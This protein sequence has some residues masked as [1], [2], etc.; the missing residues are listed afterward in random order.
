MSDAYLYQIV[1]ENR[2][3]K[4]SGTEFQSLFGHVMRATYSGFREVS[5]PP[6]RGDGGNDGWIREKGAYYQVYAPDLQTVNPDVQAQKK[7]VT[8]FE[9]LLTNWHE[10]IP[11]RRFYFVFNRRFTAVSA[12]LQKIVAQLKNKYNLEDADII[13]SRDILDLFNA[14]DEDKK[15][16]ILHGCLPLV[17]EDFSEIVSPLSNLLWKLVPTSA[18][19]MNFLDAEPPDFVEKIKF[20]KLS[21]YIQKRMELC[22]H[23]IFRI[24]DILKNNRGDA[25]IIVN[26]LKKLYESNRK[27]I[28]PDAENAPD[29]CYVGIVESIIPNEAKH[30]DT[31][32]SYSLAAE[33]IIA[34]YFESCD[35]YE[36]P[37]STVSA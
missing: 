35:I 2:V 25:Q 32:L 21:P 14:L 31:Y 29:V 36:S 19:L 37:R 22:S 27:S 13:E 33:V 30:P 4:S 28:P 1:F 20:N 26:K 10:T 8:D 24:D 7:I 16:S 17:S 9:K 3:Y 11:V 34:K 12:E 6:Y 15:K 23:H 5:A 18:E